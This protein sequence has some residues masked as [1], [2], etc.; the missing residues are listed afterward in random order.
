VGLIIPL[1]DIKVKSN[2]FRGV[3][4]PPGIAQVSNYVSQ[5]NSY[6]MEK[7]IYIYKPTS[8]NVLLKSSRMAYAG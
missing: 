1:Y 4:V 5:E 7:Y 6:V 8:L 2:N 3:V